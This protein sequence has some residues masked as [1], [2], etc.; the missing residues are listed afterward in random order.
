MG[1]EKKHH[2]KRPDGLELDRPGPFWKKHKKL[3]RKISIGMGIAIGLVF[4]IFLS[5]GG[6]GPARGP[7]WPHQK[8]KW[9]N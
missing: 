8:Q 2:G 5:E 6:L 1:H 7:R 3:P 9:E 4:L